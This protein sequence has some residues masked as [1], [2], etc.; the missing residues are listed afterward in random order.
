MPYYPS[1]ASAEIIG[2]EGVTYGFMFTFNRY[3]AGKE[4][5]GGINPSK[6]LFFAWDLFAKYHFNEHAKMSKQYDPYFYW[7]P[8]LRCDLLLQITPRSLPIQVLE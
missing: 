1:Q 5:N 7:A 6:G 8:D 3:K 2:Q 4:I